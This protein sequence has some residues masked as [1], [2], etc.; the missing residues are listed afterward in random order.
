M[1]TFNISFV[2]VLF[3]PE[4]IVTRPPIEMLS[5]PNATD[6]PMMI[7]YNCS[8]GIIMLPDVVKKLLLYDRDLARMIPKSLNLAP[9]DPRCRTVADEMRRFYFNGNQVTKENLTEM[10]KL[11]T[12]YYFSL[13]SQ[14]SAELHARH[15]ERY[16][17]AISFHFACPILICSFICRAPLFFYRFAVD[18]ELNLF[19][20]LSPNKIDIGEGKHLDGACHVDEIYYLF[21]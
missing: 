2:C 18:Q 11:Q 5:E 16:A 3:Q 15:E 7:G 6:I 1:H 14:M 21:V 4:A 13:G 9:D 8:E 19:K 10:V 12:D 17:I 20:K